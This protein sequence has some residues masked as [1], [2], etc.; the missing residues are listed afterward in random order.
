[1][2][3]PR[4]IR[5]AAA[6]AV[7]LSLTT[8]SLASAAP[9]AAGTVN[10]LVALSVFGSAQSRAA[11][12]AASSAAVAAAAT[13][14]AQSQTGCVLPVLDAPPPPVA[15]NMP[16]PV[17]DVPPPMA[18]FA[19]AAAPNLLPLLAALGLFGGAFFLL[20]DVILG[21]DDDSGF[22]IDPPTPGTPG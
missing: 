22:E 9:V 19:V 12:C 2:K 15:S 8:G 18:P 11:L 5:S 14:T 1:M 6:I 21:D 10:P 3:T 4:S 17:A 7:V 13:A 16:P 20:D